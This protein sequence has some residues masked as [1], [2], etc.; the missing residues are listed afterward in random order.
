MKDYYQILEIHPD[1][2]L[3]VMNN[4]YRA[5]VRK[6]HPDLYHTS[7]KSRMERR[8]QEINE[9][10]NVLSNAASRAEYDRRYTARA[11][12]RPTAPMP[13]RTLRRPLKN[14]LLWGIGSFVL[15]KFL[16][17]P[18]L[19]SPLLRLVLLFGVVVLLI[20]LFSRSRPS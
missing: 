17:Q 12:H 16:A 3:E 8:M 18:L 6:Y 13:A 5:L 7:D 20:R 19:A 1:A 4:A 2:S 14:M 10:Y 15:L 9:A 11:P